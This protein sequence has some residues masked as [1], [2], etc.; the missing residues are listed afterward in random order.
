[1][2]SCVNK[3]EINLK[4]PQIFMSVQKY[5]GAGRNRFSDTGT[6]EEVIF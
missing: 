1:M 3:E 5:C 4:A 2:H 6:G